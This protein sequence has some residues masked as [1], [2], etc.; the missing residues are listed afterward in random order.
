MV[1]LSEFNSNEELLDLANDVTPDASELVD[2]DLK[3]VLENS[4]TGD[5]IKFMTLPMRDILEAVE[6]AYDNDPCT[7]INSTENVVEIV[8]QLMEKAVVLPDLL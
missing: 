6:D 1:T 7:D 5:V 8:E 3:I 2:Y 4:K